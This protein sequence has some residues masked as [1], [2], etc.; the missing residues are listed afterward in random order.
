MK[1]IEARILRNAA[2]VH[3]AAEQER[4]QALRVF[5]IE[6]HIVI[7]NPVKTSGLPPAQITCGGGIQTAGH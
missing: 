2:M 6:R 5:P 7:P 4:M 1:F 3:F